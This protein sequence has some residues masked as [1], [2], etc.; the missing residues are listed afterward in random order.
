V[1]IL[2]SGRIGW[3][4]M[5]NPRRIPG[6]LTVSAEDCVLWVSGG[7][8]LGRRQADRPVVVVDAV[9]THR[10]SVPAVEYVQLL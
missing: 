7:L 9:D 2:P 8:V 6:H 10:T 5:R 4:R 1:G 3:T